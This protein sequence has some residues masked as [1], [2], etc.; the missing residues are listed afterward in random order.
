[1]DE[2]LLKNL[3][4]CGFFLRSARRG[5]KI[6]LAY[7]LQKRKRI[8]IV[9]LISAI[10]RLFLTLRFLL[11]NRSAVMKYRLVNFLG[12]FYWSSYMRRVIRYFRR[13]RRLFRK[14]LIRRRQRRRL[15]FSTLRITKIRRLKLSKI[16]RYNIRIKRSWNNF[17]I[18]AFSRFDGFVYEKL[19][20]AAS[21]LRGSKRSTATALERMCGVFIKE[22]IKHKILRKKFDFTFQGPYLSK[23]AKNSLKMF[24]NYKRKVFNRAL[25]KS[26][27]RKLKIRNIILDYNISHNGLRKPK[28]RRV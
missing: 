11:L 9:E 22:L 10:R 25:K 19:T 3:R 8:H 17:F 1:L 20:G 13:M 18:T 4:D 12:I 23:G 26:Y 14:N 21:E 15:K 27:L 5:R 24:V 28:R 6:Q 2:L 16:S 7:K